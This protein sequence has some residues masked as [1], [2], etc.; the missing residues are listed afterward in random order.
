[1]PSIIIACD[2]FKGSLTADEACTWIQKGILSTAPDHT[3][4]DVHPVADGGEGTLSILSQHLGLTAAEVAVQDPLGKVMTARYGY[5]R[6]EAYIETSASCGLQLLHVDER[7]P[8]LTHTYGV[9]QMI[10]DALAKGM[11]KI[12]L[13]VGGSATTD[14]GAGMAAA[15]GYRFRDAQGKVFTPTGGSLT[16]IKSIDDTHM[17]AKIKDS[18]FYVW[19]DVQVT[20]FGDK[21]SAHMFARQKGASDEEVALLDHGLCHLDKNFE[22]ITPQ[23]NIA[24]MAGSGAAGGL[25]A[26]CVAFLG[27]HLGSGIDFIMQKTNLESLIA[28]TDYVITGEGSIDDQSVEGKV[29][30]GVANICH[31]HHKS[32]ILIGGSA[33][34]SDENKSLLSPKHLFTILQDGMTHEYAMKHAGQRLYGIGQEIGTMI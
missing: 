29:I 1:M 20:L 8:M 4:C 13:F 3:I 34:L 28:H 2:K 21:G 18:S 22:Q 33:Y 27:A 19:T 12:H 31:K 10:A 14:G 6:D 25:A 16:I 5:L 26:G 30:S 15:L 32:L 24:G 17:D 9:G 11:K 23:K 7:N